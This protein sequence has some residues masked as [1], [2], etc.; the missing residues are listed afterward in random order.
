MAE[1]EPVIDT[2][3]GD[4]QTALSWAGALL[5]GFQST[6]TRKSYRRGAR[7]AEGGAAA[8]VAVPRRC[9]R[10]RTAGGDGVGGPSVGCLSCGP[11]GLEAVEITPG[12][13]P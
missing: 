2:D 6:G 8:H 9:A 10:C 4:W 7:A 1:F 13:L 12:G 3:D 11:S 5:A